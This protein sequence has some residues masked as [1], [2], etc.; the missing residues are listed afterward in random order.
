MFEVL[1]GTVGAVHAIF[2]QPKALGV[3]GH[4]ASRSSGRGSG[5]H[6]GELGVVVRSSNAPK[7]VERVFLWFR[8]KGACRAIA[9]IRSYI[10]ISS[11]SS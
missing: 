10:S 9:S 11:T 3:I 5:S 8:H 6:G 1:N 4:G 2:Q 7:P